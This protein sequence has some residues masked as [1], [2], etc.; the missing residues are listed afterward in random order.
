M[1]WAIFFAIELFLSL[2]SFL[3]SIAFYAFYTFA[4]LSSTI[5]DSYLVCFTSELHSLI[6]L[7]FF[8]FPFLPFKFAWEPSW[9]IKAFYCRDS[10]CDYIANWESI[11]MECC[12][13]IVKSLFEE[14]FVMWPRGDWYW[15]CPEPLPSSFRILLFLD[16]PG[17][18]LGESWLC[19]ISVAP[20]MTELAWCPLK[21]L[22]LTN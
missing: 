8:D 11:A 3:S 21:M 5:F 22:P 1:A 6:I 19:M 10:S 15:P 9:F 12:I 16:T 4:R 14:E 20:I 2:R 13:A 7:L 18:I 17:E